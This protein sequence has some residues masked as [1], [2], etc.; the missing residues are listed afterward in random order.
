M[1]ETLNGS[2]S[3]SMK[4]LS[5]KLLFVGD[6]YFFTFFFFFVYF[7]TLESCRWRKKLSNYALNSY[8]CSIESLF[9][10]SLSSWILWVIGTLARLT[11]DS[12]FF[13][14][15]EDLPSIDRLPPFDDM[16]SVSNRYCTKWVSLFWNIVVATDYVSI[17]T[18][19]CRFITRF[20][21]FIL[22]RDMPVLT[23][24]SSMSF[25]L[26]FFCGDMLLW[27][28][29]FFTGL[30]F[31]FF[32]AIFCWIPYT[33][34]F[35]SDVFLFLRLTVL[36]MVWGSMRIVFDLMSFFFCFFFFFLTFL[37]FLMLFLM[38]Y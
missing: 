29:D 7:I 13:L 27:K 19:S 6:F 4:L 36:F 22:S 24:I 33:S 3:L 2:S 31:N 20:F 15:I 11:K 35:F 10:N 23:L 26:N 25:L 18:E 37:T 38:D 9:W 30:L 21:F 8:L 34:S 14:T 16:S 1:T 17:I 12:F 28:S 5:S 32:F